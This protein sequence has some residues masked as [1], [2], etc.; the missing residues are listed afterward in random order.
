MR[1]KEPTMQEV[2]MQIARMRGE[3]QALM[4]ILSQLLARIAW[5]WDED[6]AEAY[7]EDVC[8][9]IAPDGVFDGDPIRGEFDKGFLSILNRVELYALQRVRI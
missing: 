2:G 5:D 6:K 4:M 9:I 8:A 1:I 3:N 7:V